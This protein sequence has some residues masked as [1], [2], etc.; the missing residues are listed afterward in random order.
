MTGEDRL[1]A[2]EC[3]VEAYPPAPVDPRYGL[4]FNV[5][6]VANPGHGRDRPVRLADVEF[7]G[8]NKLT[9]PAFRSAWLET[10]DKC[11]KFDSPLA[12]EPVP[13]PSSRLIGLVE[14]LPHRSLAAGCDDPLMH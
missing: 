14:P 4:A 8:P 2:D 6:P 12:F 9:V 3:L 5:C 1:S 7:H 10:G 11:L 13:H